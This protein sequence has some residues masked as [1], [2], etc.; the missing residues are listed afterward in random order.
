[1]ASKLS[2]TSGKWKKQC[3]YSP[4]KTL[5]MQH[6]L[7]L[8]AYGINGRTGLHAIWLVVAVHN[9]DTEHALVHSTAGLTARASSWI[10]V[11]ATP[12]TAQ[13]CLLS[14]PNVLHIAWYVSIPYAIVNISQ[15][16][17]SIDSIIYCRPVASF[18]WCRYKKVYL[19]NSSCWFKSRCE[20][21]FL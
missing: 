7:Q 16:T 12:L 21:T 9:G 1:M 11:T 8:M 20:L 18:T 5:I 4:M 13:V 10:S 3:F 2:D 19:F 14:H 6:F 15:C 17:L